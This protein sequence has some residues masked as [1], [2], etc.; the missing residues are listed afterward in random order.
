M[1]RILL[2]LTL[3]VGTSALAAETY[4]ETVTSS[5][6]SARSS[7]MNTGQKVLVQCDA[8]AYVVWGNSTVTASSSTGIK[9]AADST[10]DTSAGQTNAYL[11]VIS[12]TGTANC[13]IFKVVGVK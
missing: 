13:K 2:G 6:S 11:A 7:Q 4:L 12:V 8:A 5:G 3:L 1:K 10:F 9:L